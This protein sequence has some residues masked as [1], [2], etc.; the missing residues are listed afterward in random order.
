[1]EK[2]WQE[3][4]ELRQK[5]ENATLYKLFWWLG[6]AIVYWVITLLLKR[7]FINFNGTNLNEINVA[8]GLSRMLFV[9]QFAA[10]A[11]TV[12]AT[13]W[14]V[15]S[16]KQGK[17]TVA[18]FV[19]ALSMAV[20]SM[21]AIVAYHFREGGVK[22]LG[23]VAPVTA[24]LALIYFLYQREFF[25]NTL[26]TGLGIVALLVFRRYYLNHPRMIYFGFALVWMGLAVAV[27]L[28]WKFSQNNGLWGKYQVFPP[29]ISYI[30]TYLTAG[31]TAL[32]LVVTLVA[33]AFG[34]VIQTY[35]ATV[36]YY[37]IFVLIIWLFCMAVYYTVK[38]M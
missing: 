19:C 12:A 6:A 22:A 18:P 37:A 30:P 2:S 13:A 11:L 21:T 15:L 31:I 29:K 10:P 1:M 27:F 20:V 4:K 34:T 5:Q 26:L 23:L 14:Y 38:L 24:V 3:K 16:R 36:S 25:C 32:T 28:A 7:Y 9:L 33:Q 35:G 8:I 17:G